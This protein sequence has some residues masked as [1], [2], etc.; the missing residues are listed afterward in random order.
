MLTMLLP[1]LEEPGKSML[2]KVTMLLPE[3]EEPGKSMLTPSYNA[4]A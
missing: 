4:F 3:L 1:E 2:T